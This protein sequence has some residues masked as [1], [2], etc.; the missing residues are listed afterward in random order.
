MKKEMKLEAD[1]RFFH[2]LATV[3]CEGGSVEE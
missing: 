2:H 3:G 1:Q